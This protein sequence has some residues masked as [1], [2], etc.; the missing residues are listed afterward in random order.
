M[1]IQ[2]FREILFLPLDFTQNNVDGDFLA[3]AHERLISSRVWT[4]VELAWRDPAAHSIARYGE[5]HYFHRYIQ[6]VLFSPFGVNGES[7]RVL[8]VYTRKEVSG[9]R[10]NVYNRKRKKVEEVKLAIDR[11]HLFLFDVGIGILLLEASSSMPL[12]L[13]TVQTVLDVFRRV[14]PPLFRTAER[15][16]RA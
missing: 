1:E 15:Q 13:S 3:H 8:R 12:H 16:F 7:S 4:S 11:I 2:L 6:Q 5:F 14:Y 9:A 10:M